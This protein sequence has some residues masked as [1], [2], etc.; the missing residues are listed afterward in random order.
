V[1]G[2][3]ARSDLWNQIKADVLGIPYRRLRHEDTSAIGCAI[4]AG[5][6]VGVFDDIRDAADQ[7]AP[8]ADLI[9]PRAEHRD[10]YDSLVDAYRRV[11]DDLRPTYARL[12]AI[13]ES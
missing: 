2:G 5:Y 9:Q 13:R 11:F 7:L 10:I 4:I 1:T 12:T 3:G 8:T 6:A